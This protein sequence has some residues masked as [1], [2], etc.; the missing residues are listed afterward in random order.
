MIGL[1]HYTESL[2]LCHTPTIPLR[3]QPHLLRLRLQMR[4]LKVLSVLGFDIKMRS[5]SLCLHLGLKAS[6]HI[7]EPCV[8][9]SFH[10][11]KRVS[12]H[13]ILELI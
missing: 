6:S 10:A 11:A 4:P 1:L 8:P 9:G 7:L 3:Q 13:I 5:Q 12:V 2:E